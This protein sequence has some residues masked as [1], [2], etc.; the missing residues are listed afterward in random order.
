MISLF[1]GFQCLYATLVCVACSQLEKLGAAI[2]DIRQ[3]HVTSE[4][5]C[6]AETDQQ[7]GQGQ[8]RTSEE[9]FGHMQKQL[10][11]CILHHQQIIR[12]V[13]TIK[14]DGSYCV[15]RY[16]KKVMYVLCVWIFRYMLALE[17][18][19]NFALCGLFLLLLVALCFVAFSAV[20]VKYP[21]TLCNVVI[22]VHVLA[23]DVQRGYYG[24]NST[25]GRI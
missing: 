12:C 11:D 6:G 7:E 10:N 23:S 24:F 14:S 1:V 22:N 4:Q 19:M 2:L 21:L 17:N 3:T 13:Y 18:T 16:S 5:D 15:S 9:L 8:V 20:T 25:R